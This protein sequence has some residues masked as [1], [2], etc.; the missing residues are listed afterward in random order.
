MATPVAL[1]SS[2]AFAALLLFAI[3]LVFFMP[4]S[5][6]ADFGDKCTD[7]AAF[8]DDESSSACDYAKS[9]EECASGNEVDQTICAEGTET[10]KNLPAAFQGAW[11]EDE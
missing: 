5:A 6:W 11:G 4:S 3:T 8:A 7:A 2:S 1:K 10:T 9:A